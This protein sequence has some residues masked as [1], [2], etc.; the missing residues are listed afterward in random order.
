MKLGLI[1]RGDRGGLGIQTQEMH[2]H[3]A[4]AVTLA[5]DMGDKARGP[6]GFPAGA[7]VSAYDATA[8]RLPTWDMEALLSRCDVLLTA[9]GFYDDRLIEMARERNVKT[10][11]IANFELMGWNRN[12]A[13]MPDL[14]I[15]PSDW[16]LDKWPSNSIHIPFPVA[17]DRL[18]FTLRTEAKRFL[19]IVAP[20]MVDRSGTTMVMKALR[21][22]RSAV[23]VTIHCQSRRVGFQHH[24]RLKPGVRVNIRTEDFEH[25]PDIYADHDVLLAPRRYGGLSL[26]L[27]EASSLGMP[28]ITLDREPESRIVCDELRIRSFRSRD[29]EMKGGTVQ[30]LDADPRELA[31]CIDML[32]RDPELMKR[33]SQQAGDYAESISW[34]RVR[35]ELLTV[36]ASLR[37]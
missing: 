29:V 28:T 34:E 35:P 37:R 3:L 23:D 31:R 12:E 30:V 4:P 17:R 9:E 27:N 22:I 8:Y 19:H 16:M 18:P 5:V 7:I 10:A 25:Y 2:R 33:S 14:F 26:P 32:A 15:A 21:H 1:L 6:Q 11:V 20:A 13:P 36:L 24:H